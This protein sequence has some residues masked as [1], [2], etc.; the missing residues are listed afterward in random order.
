MDEERDRG[1]RAE[2]RDKKV[3]QERRCFYSLQQLPPRHGAHTC[4]W[5][6]SKGARESQVEINV[7]SGG[8]ETRSRDRRTRV[9]EARRAAG[10]RG[11]GLA[12]TADRGARHR[13]VHGR[14]AQPVR[15]PQAR[16]HLSAHESQRV[17]IGSGIAQ[18]ARPRAKSAGARRAWRAPGSIPR[19]A[20]ARRSPGKGRGKSEH[21]LTR[22]SFPLPSPSRHAPACASC[23][24]QVVQPLLQLRVKIVAAAAAAAV[25]S[26]RDLPFS[27]AGGGRLRRGHR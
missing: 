26:R 7:C 4:K 27:R 24:P 5:H 13:S 12:G 14:R 10:A 3:I 23:A 2:V 15:R 20:R 21:R 25:A 19:A 6:K 18:P 11:E 22:A 16:R 9:R 8:L 1:V 17:D